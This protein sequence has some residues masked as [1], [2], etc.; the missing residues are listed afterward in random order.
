VSIEPK[1]T[2][3][4]SIQTVL[5][6]FQQTLSEAKL[7]VDDALSA[8]SMLVGYVC[9][10][11]ANEEQAAHDSFALLVYDI[12]RYIAENWDQVVEIRKMQAMKRRLQGE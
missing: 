10:N 5:E 11:S 3:P 8:A 1:E 2:C 9:L 7:P 12:H 4:P 6:I